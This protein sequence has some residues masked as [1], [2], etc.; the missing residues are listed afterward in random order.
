M[1]TVSSFRITCSFKEPSSALEVD[2]LDAP[3]WDEA[4]KLNAGRQHARLEIVFQWY[5][6]RQASPVSR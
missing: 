3:T 2:D 5:R 4:T 1:N 6:P